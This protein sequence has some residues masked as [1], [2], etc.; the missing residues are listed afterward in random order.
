MSSGFEMRQAGSVWLG[1]SLCAASRPLQL[2]FIKEAQRRFL[3]LT[4]FLAMR[5]QCEIKEA[6][7]GNEAMA[8]I[9]NNPCDV[10]I[11]DI[12]MPKK[13]G[14]DV[15]KETKAIKPDIDILVI[16]A[17]L[18]DDVSHEAVRLGANDYVIKP[19]DLK[20]FNLKFANILEKRGQ[21]FSKI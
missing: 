21:K 16:S 11:L 7:D 10:M 13:G 2:Q 6:Q 18:S 14:I 5:Y 20:V 12:R 9:K 19:L 4:D 17:W 3:F 15:I 1:D 8:F